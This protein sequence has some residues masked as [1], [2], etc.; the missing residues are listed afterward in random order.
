MYIKKSE[1][2]LGSFKSNNIMPKNS[3]EGTKKFTQLCT[4]DQQGTYF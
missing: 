1:V 3:N 2:Q 4:G